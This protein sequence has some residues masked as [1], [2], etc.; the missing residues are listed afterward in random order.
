M[1]EMDSTID[2]VQLRLVET[3]DY[4]RI[5]FYNI[6]EPANPAGYEGRFHIAAR[7][8]GDP[9]DDAKAINF[10]YG[11]GNTGGGTDLMSIKSDG[12]VAIGS[13]SGN[14]AALNVQAIDDFD[15]D[16]RLKGQG[17]ISSQGSI[18]L[19]LDDNNNSSTDDAF[20]I[21]SGADVTVFEVFENGDVY[22]RGSMVHSSDRSRKENIVSVNS[23]QILDQ[24]AKLDISKWNFK[25]DDYS[26][27]GP[28]AQDF[29]AAFGLGG[30]DKGIA[31]V[32]SDGV[33]L[34]AI[35]ALLKRIEALEALLKERE[36]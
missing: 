21:R 3:D 27:L 35:Q 16:I 13:T 4:A 19:W 11:S 26:H 36:E 2:D 10:W 17:R 32:D 23:A 14:L 15:Q 5:E 28:M 34:A 24:V 1:L 7:S 25:G 30:T 12:R 20:E 33:A 29:Y 6:P 31:T 8:Y 22:V 18:A 9:A